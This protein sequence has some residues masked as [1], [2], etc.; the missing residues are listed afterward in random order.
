MFLTMFVGLYT[1]RVVLNT[2]GAEDY[3]IYGVVG[4]IVAM[5]GFL[6]S[7]MSVATSRFLTFEIGKG[8]AI[9]LSKTFSSAM[10]VHI[11]IAI[12]IIIFSETVGL[13]FLCNKL[14]IPEERMFAAHVVYQLSVISVI[15]GVTQVPYNSCII[16]HEK[17]D[18]YAYVEIVNV[19]LK[20]IIVYLLMIGNF[21]KLI[22]Y[23]IL[24]LI[25]SIFIV[26]VYRVYCI[27]KFVESKFH[28][29]WDKEYIRPMLSFSGW[30]IYYEG[31]FAVRQ[32]GVNFLLNMFC[33]LV[34]NAASGIAT[35]VQGIVMT[36]SSNTIMAFRPQ[37]IK[38]YAQGDFDKMNSLIRMGTKFAA[39]LILAVTLPLLFKLEYILTLWLGNVPE[40]SIFM[41]QCLLIVNVVNTV[42]VL[43]V[44]GIQ[45]TGK[46]KLYSGL[47]GSI[48]LLSVAVMYVMMKFHF[49]Y[50]AIYTVI[51]ATS[52]VVNFSYAC[53]LKRQI[54]QFNIHTYYLLSVGPIVLTS[55]LATAALSYCAPYF[56]DTIAGLL[57]FGLISAVVIIIISL[58]IVLTSSER[59]YIMRFVK[60][61]LHTKK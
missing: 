60:S 43:L 17:M 10:V 14:V 16:A 52:F 45:A 6:N 8:D 37:V 44:T 35:T 15:F 7:S 54:P 4:G 59:Q 2:L 26:L 18:V 23:A 11:L 42:S 32:Q 57:A 25:V 24:M 38:S 61:K 51:L 55:I 5:V 27:R 1:S 9:R 41:L 30:N 36:F 12:I 53:M 39:V 49:D 48:Y 56:T 22:L 40:G 33:G 31:A 47:C 13:W 20:L 19:T 58:C 28:W 21:D 29:I 50:Q 46:L 3:G 34:Y